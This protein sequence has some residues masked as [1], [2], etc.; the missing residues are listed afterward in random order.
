MKRVNRI[1][2]YFLGLFIIAWGINLAIL[3]DLGVSPVSAFTVPLSGVVHRSLGSVTAVCY[4]GFVIIE[5]LVLGRQFKIKNLLQIP[6]SIIFGFFVDFIGMILEEVTLPGYGIRFVVMICSIIICAA[7]AA[8]YITM[9]I[10]PNAPEGLILAFCERFHKEY[11]RLKILTDCIFVSI[12]ILLSLIFLGGV[13][14][15]R[16]GTIISAL[17]T[18][19]LTGVFLNRWR[20]KLQRMTES[21][22]GS[23]Y[24]EGKSGSDSEGTGNLKGDSISGI[25]S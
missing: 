20:E 3:S 17:V 12:G 6:F 2:L 7:G 23:G 22:R 24:D 21:E 4:G 13:S 9:D 16:E 15:I 25:E 19:K 10:V 1:L 14:A 11:G 5:I 8:I 18:G